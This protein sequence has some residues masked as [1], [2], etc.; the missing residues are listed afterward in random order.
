MYMPRVKHT[1]MPSFVINHC[2]AGWEFSVTQSL[3]F[4]FH[5]ESLHKIEALAAIELNI[6][7]QRKLRKQPLTTE[8]STFLSLSN[9]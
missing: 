3:S 1:Q 9:V 7:I 5:E 2:S 8:N 4:I 6:E